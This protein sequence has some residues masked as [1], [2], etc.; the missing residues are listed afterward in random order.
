MSTW[1]KSLTD[2]L[3]DYYPDII[4][5]HFALACL[6]FSAALLLVLIIFISRLVKKY[7]NI[8]EK[9]LTRI[10]NSVVNTILVNDDL[11]DLEAIQATYR[12]NMDKLY[13]LCNN[14]RKKQVLIDIL[15]DLKKNFSGTAG[16]IID[17]IYKDLRLSELS[18]RKLK[19]FRWSDKAKGVKELAVFNCKNKVREIS[20]LLNSSNLILRNEVYFALIQLSEDNPLGFLDNYTGK[21]TLWQELNFLHHLNLIDKT[22]VPDFSRWFNSANEDVVLFSISMTV[23]FRQMT[24]IQKLVNLIYHNSYTIRFNAAH[25]LGE[26]EAYNYADNIAQI[27]ESC[28]GDSKLSILWLKSMAKIGDKDAH[29]DVVYS[30]L[31][32]PILAVRIQAAHTLL[33]MGCSQDELSG[34]DSTHLRNIFNHVNEPLLK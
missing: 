15:L 4:F 6:F 29:K 3:L 24:S 28:R 10:V 34:I 18:V 16:K 1:L 12:Y 31:N 21:I 5:W 9:E 14:N 32:D 11:K 33:Q 23:R 20:R 22:K 30:F 13:Y 2:S 17:N 19:N 8:R 26:L 7:Q 27:N 25:A